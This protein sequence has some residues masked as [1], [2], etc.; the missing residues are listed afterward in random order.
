MLTSTYIFKSCRRL[1]RQVKSVTYSLPALHSVR[2]SN[3][4]DTK[5]I[6]LVPTA[7]WQSCP[8]LNHGARCWNMRRSHLILLIP[9]SGR[10]VSFSGYG[11]TVAAPWIS[12]LLCHLQNE[13]WK[14][15]ILKVGRLLHNDLLLRFSQCPV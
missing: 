14:Q 7:F 6:V 8:P 4:H 9:V 13:D 12:Y 1:S 15:K 2:C 11:Y 3:Y 5:W 10:F